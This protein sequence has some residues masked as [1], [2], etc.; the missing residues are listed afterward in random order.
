MSPKSNDKCP[1]KR[2][3]E[4][5]LTQKKKRNRKRRQLYEDGG[6]NYSCYGLNYDSRMSYVEVLLP[7]PSAYACILGVMVYT[8]INKVK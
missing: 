3:A 2:K 4:E 8:V 7:R 6:R 5:D 1:F